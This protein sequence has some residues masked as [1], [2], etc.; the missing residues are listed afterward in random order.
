M[1][2]R[3]RAGKSREVK[4]LL[5]WTSF[6]ECTVERVGGAREEGME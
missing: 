6:G 2:G 1:G 5:P 4:E 3:L